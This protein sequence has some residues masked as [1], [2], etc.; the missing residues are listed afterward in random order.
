VGIRNGGKKKKK[1]R[2]DTKEE[3]SGERGGIEE[4]DRKTLNQSLLSDHY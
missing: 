3:G 4:T 2:G 1:G